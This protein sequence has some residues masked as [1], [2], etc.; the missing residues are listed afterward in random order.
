MF[1]GVRWNTR[2]KARLRVDER[3]AGRDGG[4]V[5]RAAAAAMA[6]AVTTDVTAVLATGAVIA[7]AAAA[8]AVLAGR[9]DGRGAERVG[10]V[11]ERVS[12]GRVA[13]CVAEHAAEDGDGRLV[14]HDGAEAASAVSEIA[15]AA[16]AAEAMAAAANAAV[17]STA[18]AMEAAAAMR[19]WRQSLRWRRRR[20]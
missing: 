20:C 4:G 2:L 13:D 17:M 15:A 14:R 10:C 7:T 5:R 18:V 6:E 8:T 3:A 9:A 11:V 12:F 1:K 16:T 19:W